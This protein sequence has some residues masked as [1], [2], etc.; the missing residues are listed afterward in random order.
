[1]APSTWRP[2]LDHITWKGPSLAPSDSCIR[3]EP[4][5]PSPDGLADLTEAVEWVWDQAGQK[6]PDEAGIRSFLDENCLNKYKGKELGHLTAGEFKNVQDFLY[7]YA[8]I[9]D[10]PGKAFG[11]VVGVLYRAEVRGPPVS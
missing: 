2:N 1:M 6:L 10:I 9:F 8:D 4:V 5:D 11:C 3:Y 7:V